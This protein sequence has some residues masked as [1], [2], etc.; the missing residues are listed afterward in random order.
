MPDISMCTNDKCFMRKSCYRF[1]A[2]P[3]QYSQSYMGFKPDETGECKDFME[4][5][6]VGD[7]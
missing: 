2:K 3:S 5:Y 4:L 7:E 6:K 1:M